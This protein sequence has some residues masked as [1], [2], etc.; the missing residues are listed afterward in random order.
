[1]SLFV[2]SAAAVAIG[3]AALSLGAAA[4]PAEAQ[5]ARRLTLSY[6]GKLL[7]KVLDIDVVQQVDAD[8]YESTIRLKSSGV[9]SAFKKIQQTATARGTIAGGTARPGWFRHQNVDGKR[10]RR[11]EVRWTGGDVVTSATP[12]YGN[13]GHPPA[14]KA[15]RLESADPVTQLVRIALGDDRND[16]CTGAMKF[17]DG[18]QR[19]N[20]E[21][22]G[23]TLGEPNAR[24]KKLGLTSPV[25]CRVVYREIAGFKKKPPEKRNQGLNKPINIAFARVGRDGPWVISSLTGSTPLGAATIELSAISR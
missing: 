19:Y 6:D 1:M 8:S 23:R 21:F 15:Q 10:N 24:E 2:R 11:V 25:R 16:F 4:G 7:V 12:A 9:L 18:K 5:S 17:F 3:A 14:S 13:M 20:L 22:S